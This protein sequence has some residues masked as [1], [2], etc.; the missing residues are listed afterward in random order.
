MG[1]LKDDNDIRSFIKQCELETKSNGLKVKRTVSFDTIQKTINDE[2]VPMFS[3]TT[4]ANT[5]ALGKM[6]TFM[7]TGKL[8]LMIFPET[9]KKEILILLPCSSDLAKSLGFPSDKFGICAVYLGGVPERPSTEIM[10]RFKG[11]PIIDMKTAD[12]QRVFYLL[13]FPSELSEKIHRGEKIQIIGES[14]YAKLLKEAYSKIKITTKG[15]ASIVLIDRHLLTPQP[16][17]RR[18]KKSAINMYEFGAPGDVAKDV[19][20]VL[21]IFPRDT[22]GYITTDAVNLAKDPLLISKIVKFAKQFNGENPLRNIEVVFQDD[23]IDIIEDVCKAHPD[24]KQSLE[25]KT[26]LGMHNTME[27]IKFLRI[28]P[29]VNA[30]LATAEWMT[31]LASHEKERRQLFIYVDDNEVIKAKKYQAL[32]L[33]KSDRLDSF[34]K[35]Q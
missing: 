18:Y 11:C 35:K 33:T 32:D 16:E 21:P 5:V 13:N 12:L 14:V 23:I 7:E 30:K 17:F 34:L 1:T 2:K 25:A 15:P 28:W 4:T 26:M 9:S 10:T 31:K 20:P 22:G 8:G 19:P 27:N 6:R 24:K 29:G 3:V